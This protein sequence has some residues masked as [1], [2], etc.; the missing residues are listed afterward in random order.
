[1]EYSDELPNPLL[2]LPREFFELSIP[3]FLSLLDEKSISRPESKA[4]L[5][6][7]FRVYLS[8][9]ELQFS[10]WFQNLLNPCFRASLRG[11]KKFRLKYPNEPSRQTAQQARCDAL[12]LQNYPRLSKELFQPFLSSA[13]ILLILRTCLSS[14]ENF[15]SKKDFA[16]SMASFSE[17]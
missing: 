11:W 2:F 10:L 17:M 13:L 5:R 6:F 14:P 8:S 1:M 12:I 4:I 3:D 9:N 16:I 15:V 7:F